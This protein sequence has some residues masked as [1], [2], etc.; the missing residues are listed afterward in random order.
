MIRTALVFF[1]CFLLVLSSLMLISSK[2][3]VH[4][5]IN[6]ILIFLHATGLLL[7]EQ[8]EF[9][10]F[11]LMIIYVGAIAVLFLFVLMLLNIKIIET[12]ILL[13]RYMPIGVFVG[14]LFFFEVLFLSNQAIAATAF[15][16]PLASLSAAFES[17]Y[18]FLV[19]APSSGLETIG[20]FLYGSGE[21]RASHEYLIIT[22]YILMLA[23]IG[24][25]KLTLRTR[26]SK[27]Q[28][29]Y[30]QVST[31]TTVQLLKKA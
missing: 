31:S 16:D 26:K 17:N 20:L 3:P 11:I 21:G 5:I 1:L 23:M 25:I 27:S 24:A 28:E 9:M 19:S 30:E 10:G 13:L 22:A 12:N 6:L 29:T 14:S 2:H 15:I 8:L 18:S 4:A 7:V